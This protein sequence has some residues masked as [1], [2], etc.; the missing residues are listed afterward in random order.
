MFRSLNEKIKMPTFHV[1]VYIPNRPAFKI[2]TM[3]MW[4]RRK[5]SKVKTQTKN[6]Y[7]ISGTLNIRRLKTEQI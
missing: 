5:H 1:L 6:T 2:T 4:Q 7:I 3:H